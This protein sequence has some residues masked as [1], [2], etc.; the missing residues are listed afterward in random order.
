METIKTSQLVLTE[1]TTE[2][3]ISELKLKFSSALGATLNLIKV[4]QT[5]ISIHHVIL[6]KDQKQWKY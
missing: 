6:I 5:T 4:E 1:L 3:A 2:K